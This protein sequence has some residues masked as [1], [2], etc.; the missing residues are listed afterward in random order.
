MTKPRSN[1]SATA[2]GYGVAHQAARRRW[3]PM[4]ERGEVLC[5][6]CGRSIDPGT[7]WDLSHPK[8]DKGLPPE[9]WHASC[10]RAYA[11]A[12]TGP[13]R[14][15][16]PAVAPP[17]EPEWDELTHPAPW[18]SPSGLTWSRNWTGEGVTRAEWIARHAPTLESDPE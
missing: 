2:R 7:P 16:S 15:R 10:N 14:R 18:R 1:G 9:P 6:R 8:D 17:R 3:A 12:V 4:V 11:S 5:G 13:R